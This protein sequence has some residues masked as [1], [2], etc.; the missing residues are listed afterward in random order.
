[1]SQATAIGLHFGT[2][3]I[4]TFGPY[5]PVYTR[6]YHPATDVMMLSAGLYLAL[7]Y[8]VTA[9]L[10]LRRG[11]RIW[12]FGYV[13]FMAGGLYFPDPLLFSLPLLLGLAMWDGVHPDQGWLLRGKRG[14]LHLALLFAPLGLLPLIKGS[15]LV[16]CCAVALLC[17]ALAVARR[18]RGLAVA[19][20]LG[21]LSG[22]IFFWLLAGQPILTLPTYITSMLPIIAGYSEAMAYPGVLRET[23]AFLI[24]GAALGWAIGRH[25]FEAQHAKW[26][27]GTL[28]AVYLFLAF[29]AGFVRHDGHAAIAASSLVMAA[30]ALPLIVGSRTAVAGVALSVLSWVWI[31]YHYMHTS[32]SAFAGNVSSTYRSTWNGASLRLS[33]P[34]WP[35]NDFDAALDELRIKS[36]LPR[37]PGST[38]IYSYQQSDLIASGNHWSPRPVLQSYSAYTPVLAE[39]NRQHLLGSKSPNNIL[40]RVETIDGR[41]PALDDG[42]SW[43]TLLARYRPMSVLSDAV[44][45]RK[46][47]AMP[48]SSAANAT[49]LV[50][51]EFKFGEAVSIPAEQGKIFVQMDIKPSLLGRLAGLAFRT[52]RL[53]LTVK[54]QGGESKT[55]RLVSGMAR[56]GFI[57]SPLVEN[58]DEFLMLYGDKSLMAHKRVESITL[59]TSSGT[60]LLWSSTYRVRLDQLPVT[61][62]ADVATMLKFDRFTAA[63]MPVATSTVQCEGVIDSIN[64]GPPA[65]SI[66]ARGLLRVQGWMTLLPAPRHSASQLYVVLTDAN[67]A[68]KFAPAHVITRPDVA[69]HF[70]QPELRDSGYQ[71]NADLSEM[72]GDYRFG[73]AVEQQGQL[74]HCPQ[75]T[76]QVSIGHAK[77]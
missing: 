76:L 4:F 22:L 19:C 32:V 69:V 44:L 29:K 63:P 64:S 51:G 58:N 16:L 40:F 25:P 18:Q 72:R 17:V 57:V 27:F 48:I 52:D 73:L 59:D 21:P 10:A 28:Y 66:D 34:V 7:A 53:Q 1:M 13:V 14:A 3:V 36:E 46:L 71:L 49:P 6:L 47:D 61:P 56:A 24:A 35:R 60:T 33:T 50:S 23:A 15:L 70:Q 45:L 30:L 67:G 43:P 11:P 31:D 39:L 12:T 75:P 38:D 42:P 74:Y 62:P 77:P 37:L 9:F 20:L 8:W 26:F 2:D 65:A 55:F 41:L 68:Q 5:A 54:L